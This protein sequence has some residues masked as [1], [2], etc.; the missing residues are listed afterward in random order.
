MFR[1]SHNWVVEKLMQGKMQGTDDSD[2]D[3]FAEM[4]NRIAKY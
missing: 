3:E 1:Q 4:R 2:T